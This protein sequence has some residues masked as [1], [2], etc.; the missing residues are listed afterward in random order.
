MTSNFDLIQYAE[1]IRL[2]LVGVFSKDKLPKRPKVGNY[3]INM[4]DDDAGDGSH[5]V[6]LRVEPKIA[7]Y[8]DSFGVN[9]PRD[10]TRFVRRPLAWAEKQIQHLESPNCGFYTLFF[11]KCLHDGMLPNDILNLFDV[12]SRENDKKLETLINLM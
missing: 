4:E 11:L 12:N 10:V 3:V 7:Y 9:P 1:H 2:P 8:F 6:G 5:W